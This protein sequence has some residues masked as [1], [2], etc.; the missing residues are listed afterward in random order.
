MGTGEVRRIERWLATARVFLATAALVTV[1]MDPSEIRYS[2][3]A[4]GL[5]AFYLAQSVV[6]ILLLRRRQQSTPSFRLL[7]H[8][9]DVIWPALISIFATS[10]GNPFFLFFVFVIAAAAYRWGLWETV[11]TASLSVLLLWMDSLAFNLGLIS[12]LDGFLL[13]HHLPLLRSD[14]TEFEP[15]RLF[16]RSISLLVMGFLLGYLAEQQKQLRAEK[17]VIAR[18]LAKARV[19]VGLRSTLQDIIGEMLSL[20]EAGS[21]LIVSQE[22][23]SRHVFIGELQPEPKVQPEAKV[24]AEFRWLESS[25]SGREMYLYDDQQV[26]AC[27]ASRPP[28]STE[29][30]NVVGMNKDGE[31]VRN[32]E[33]S[34]LDPLAAQHK[35]DSM[36]SVSFLFGREWWGRIF[37]FDPSLTGDIEEEL[38]FLQELV[39]QVG[40]AVYNVYLLSR[41]RTRAG[42]VE[43]ARVARELHDGAV[44]SLI[45]V[46]MQVDV[47]RRQS[48]SNT[49]IVTGELGRIQ[50]LLREEVLKLRELMQQMKS[51]D[52]DSRRLLGF[53]GDTVERFQRETGISARF[54]TSIEELKMP[55][56]MCREIARIVQEALVNVRKHS[57]ATQVLVRFNASQDGWNLVIED[58]GS[59]F[60]FAGRLNQLELD[61]VGKGPVVIGERVRL[62]DGE[63]TVESNPGRGSR[64]EVSIPQQRENAYG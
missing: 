20:Y 32:I 28:G 36:I 31:R 50:G 16:M 3:W 55:Q 51:I 40:P 26:T 37:L 39:L 24:G 25:T 64:L 60:P 7:V 11:G 4:H 34:F 15:K 52:L 27:Y 29:K 42:A 62:I 38:R 23:N 33:V 6:I 8:S 22:T 19:E 48:V 49:G 47:L 13:R 14:I 61:S 53:I 12:G 10:Q 44:Q 21:A 18:V 56:P 5:L 17:A 63:L 58:D 46:E 1:W 59:G 54:I 45:A 2:L 30:F 41:L 9:G 35:F 43:R 57:K